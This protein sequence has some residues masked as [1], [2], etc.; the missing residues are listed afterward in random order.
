MADTNLWAVQVGPTGCLVA[1]PNLAEASAHA[2]E[3]NALGLEARHLNDAARIRDHH[4]CDVVTY[5]VAARVTEWPGTVETHRA[6]IAA[7]RAWHA[8][9]ERTRLAELDRR[10]ALTIELASRPCDC[11]EGEPWLT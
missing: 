10:T 7:D 4:G 9:R 11:C 3:L 5:E 6:D 2:A 8:E 1:F